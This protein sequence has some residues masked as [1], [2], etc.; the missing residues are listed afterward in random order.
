MPRFRIYAIGGVKF[1]DIE[2]E[3]IQDVEDFYR[4][5]L[6]MGYVAGIVQE[7]DGAR[8]VLIPTRGIGVI[9]EAPD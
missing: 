3:A 9:T 6:R 7:E 4:I 2:D 8:K 5:A 1:V